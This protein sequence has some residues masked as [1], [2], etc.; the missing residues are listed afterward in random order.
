[1]YIREFRLK[2]QDTIH[3]RIEKVSY[4]VGSGQ[5]TNSHI[6]DINGYIFQAPITY[7]TQDRKWDMAPGFDKNNSRFERLLATE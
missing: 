4:I 7:Y 5:H 2:N 3:N 1:M 6:I